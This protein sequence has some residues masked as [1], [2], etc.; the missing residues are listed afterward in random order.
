MTDGENTAEEIGREVGH[1][2]GG[3]EATDDA[4]AHSQCPKQGNG[5]VFPH[6]SSRCDPL[7]ST[8]TGNGKH[9]SRQHGIE[10]K[11]YTKTYTSE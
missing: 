6:L 11:T 3:E 2:P 8:S 5:R 1:E 4:D 7:H 10:P 9:H